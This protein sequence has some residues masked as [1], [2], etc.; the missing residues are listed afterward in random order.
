MPLGDQRTARYPGSMWRSILRHWVLST[1]ALFALLP[2]LALATLFIIRQTPGC[3]RWRSE[4]MHMA[5]SGLE[6]AYG[7]QNREEVN[8]LLRSHDSN[9]DE[10]LLLLKEQAEFRLRDSQP[11]GCF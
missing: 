10:V 3:Q 2:I 9:Y 4:V 11:A 5:I 8:D 1:V 6:P 7:S